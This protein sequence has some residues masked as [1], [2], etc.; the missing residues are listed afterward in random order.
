M[1]F[2]S[3]SS[4]NESPLSLRRFKCTEKSIDSFSL[5]VSL[6]FSLFFF[7]VVDDDDDLAVVVVVV[8]VV[9]MLTIVA[10]VGF[11]VICF[12]VEAIVVVVDGFL[13]EF[14]LFTSPYYLGPAFFF[15][16]V[17][18]SFSF[19]AFIC[20]SYGFCSRCCCCYSRHGRCCCYCCRRSCCF[21]DLLRA[22]F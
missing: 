8:A 15:V 9:A 6:F 5:F 12:S 22:G 10:V 4:V 11:V 20:C 18:P 16:G 21:G 17:V 19:R 14:F 2:F 1:C 13:W 3:P 7:V